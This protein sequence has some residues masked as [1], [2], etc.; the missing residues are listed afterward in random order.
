MSQNKILLHEMSLM[1]C[2][3]YCEVFVTKD[4]MWRSIVKIMKQALHIIIS[5]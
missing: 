4:W 2:R 1:I 3:K 5:F